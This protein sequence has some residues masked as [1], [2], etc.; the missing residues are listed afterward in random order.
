MSLALHT[1]T[2]L[3]AII[4]ATL[5]RSFDV[6]TACN[7]TLLA[8][9][10]L[11]GWVAY[12]LAY[13]FTKE[14]WPSILAGLMF[15]TCAYIAIHLLGHF[16]LIH[17]W[18]FALVALMWIRFLERPHWTRGLGVGAALA[19]AT[20][21][22]YY[23][24]VYALIIAGVWWVAST[25]RLDWHVTKRAR[26]RRA[27]LVL[28]AVLLAADAVLC[29]TILFTGGFEIPLGSHLVSV[30]HLHNPASVLWALLIVMAC[31]RWT[32][33]QRVSQQPH[34]P[35]VTR[36]L[37]GIA[38]GALMYVVLIAP[39]VIAAIRLI[40]HGDYVTEAH[41]W[42]T[43]PRGIDLATLAL[44][45]PMQSFY[46]RWSQAAYDAIHVNVM[47]QS[48]WLGIVPIGMLI[49]AIRARGARW[50]NQPWAIVGIVFFL[51]SLGPFLT[52]GATDT[53]LILPQAIIRYVP[54]LSNA[55]IPGRTFIVVELAGAILAAMSLANRRLSRTAI[56]ALMAL[57]VA[58]S[59]VAPFPIYPVPVAGTVEALLQSRP[60]GSILELPAG[61]ADGFGDPGQ[62]DRRS[63]SWQ[64]AHGHPLVGGFIARV[65]NRIRRGYQQDPLLWSIL[66]LSAG[67][68]AP[69]TAELPADPT[70][71]LTDLG[72]RYVAINRD[73][74]P[75]PVIDFVLARVRL[76]QIAADGPRELYEVR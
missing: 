67:A 47:E 43:G 76:R 41:H 9:L 35:S 23:Y 55:R 11:N 10:T 16:N 34:A 25:Y 51:W 28:L 4:G 36:L 2:A 42:L 54:I 20:Y 61:V 68:P 38:P 15:G 14:A 63:L 45:H 65:S 56:A 66:R 19:A 5:L 48:A 6:V 74:A 31:L 58:D 24:T 71:H 8:G 64:M 33:V 53:A 32:L 49:V 59:F 40:A 70:Q 22:D 13:H 30:R 18:T 7:L 62:F 75:Q 57:V 37:R 39:V 46:G 26:P 27:L 1:H 29:A 52:I 21:T 44:G 60:G 72:V 17:P 69:A 12:L 3:P 73:T 50:L